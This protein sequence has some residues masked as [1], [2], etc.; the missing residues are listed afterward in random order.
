MIIIIFSSFY[1]LIIKFNLRVLSNWKSS[2]FQFSCNFSQCKDNDIIHFSKN[3]VKYTVGIS[4]SLNGQYHS[5]CFNYRRISYRLKLQIGHYY[6]Y[7][8][9]S[10]RLVAHNALQYVQLQ[11]WINFI[12]FYSIIRSKWTDCRQGW[13]N[14]LCYSPGNWFPTAF[15]IQIHKK[16]SFSPDVVEDCVALIII[17]IVK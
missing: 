1:Y 2:F 5:R 9:L 12:N 3:T 6:Y 15:I 7:F 8:F 17:L 10:L 11:F 13:T 16:P 14:P 4:V